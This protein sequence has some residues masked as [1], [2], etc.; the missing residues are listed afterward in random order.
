LI[1]KYHLEQV[2]E[3]WYEVLEFIA[4]LVIAMNVIGF[5][6]SKVMGRMRSKKY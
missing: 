2:E 4:E 6:I 5:V 1:G 3:F